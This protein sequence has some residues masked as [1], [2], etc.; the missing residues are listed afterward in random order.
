MCCRP[1]ESA[2]WRADEELV[3]RQERLVRWLVD[4][5]VDAALV[6]RLRAA[7]H[8]VEYVAESRAG[9]TDRYLLRL[10]TKIACC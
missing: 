5:C 9:A 2:D 7:D 10:A 8:D 1:T 6:A 4:E 3:F